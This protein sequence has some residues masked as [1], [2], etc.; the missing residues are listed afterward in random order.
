[1]VVVM[2]A[3]IGAV[4]GYT[5]YLVAKEMKLDRPEM[6]LVFVV[7]QAYFFPVNYSALTE[8]IAAAL[9]SLALLFHLRS[10]H[11]GFAICGSLLPLARPEL[12]IFVVIWAVVLFQKRTLLLIPLLGV[13]V[14]LWGV[15]SA[16]IQGDILALPN[17]IFTGQENRYG[18]GT[19]YTYPQRYIWATGPVVFYLAFLGFIGRVFR[20]KL[21]LLLTLMVTGFIIYVIFSW[22]LSIGHAAGFLRNLVVLA[23]M[24]GILALEGF[25][26]WWPRAGSVVGKGER[27]WLALGS[28]VC[29]LLTVFFWSYVLHHHHSVGQ[30]RDYTNLLFVGGLSLLFVLRNFVLPA[31]RSSFADV[32]VTVAVALLVIGYTLVTEPPIGLTPERQ[33]M[34]QVASWHASKN[35][36]GTTYVNHPWFFYA[37]G[38]MPTDAGFDLVTVANLDSARSGDL[39]IWESHYAHRLQGDVQMDYFKENPDWVPVFQ[40][41][42]SDRRFSTLVFRRR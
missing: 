22:K 25:N 6:G 7:F 9:I 35:V 38:S 42:A 32:F 11:L 31:L 13:P 10:Q 5:C 18:H 30:E 17:M 15:A 23:P 28:A 4:T 39:V 21:D 41:L 40:R 34:K 37:H 3:L 16:I 27:L 33:L 19:W 29:V 20:R 14:L 26:R 8:P 36:S 24:A 2:T 1:M 12:S